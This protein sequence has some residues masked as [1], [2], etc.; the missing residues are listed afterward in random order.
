MMSDALPT[1]VICPGQRPLLGDG[2]TYLRAMFMVYWERGYPSARPFYLHEHRLQ[3][4]LP[5]IAALEA[6]VMALLNHHT[7]D[8]QVVGTV[9]LGYEGI[10][11]T[12]DEATDTGW[13][14]LT[15]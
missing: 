2:S 7:N 5:G 10:A 9:Y 15:R 1:N 4:S 12:D 13:L 3:L 11:M 14:L 6:E 8:K